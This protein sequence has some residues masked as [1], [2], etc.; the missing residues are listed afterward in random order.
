MTRLSGTARDRPSISTAGALSYA[1]LLALQPSAPDWP[2]GV[3]GG[4]ADARERP[5]PVSGLS[6]QF[7]G[8]VAVILDGRRFLDGTATQI[9]AFEGESIVSFSNGSA[10][11]RSKR[12]VP[13]FPG[14]RSRYC[15]CSCT[16]LGYWEPTGGME[17]GPVCCDGVVLPLCAAGL[18][19]RRQYRTARRRALE[20]QDVLQGPRT[21]ASVGAVHWPRT[22]R[23]YENHSRER[24]RG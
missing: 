16:L 5:P 18:E 15:R 17:S 2:G 12:R 10:R 22:G 13:E 3:C 11:G 6:E 21:E 19:L 9:L 8:C 24:S 23:T 1:E 4:L 7:D 20:V 14:A